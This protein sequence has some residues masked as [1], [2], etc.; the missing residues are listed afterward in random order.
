MSARKS[1]EI[2]STPL[3]PSLEAKLHIP[4]AE[5]SKPSFPWLVRSAAFARSTSQR[6]DT[7]FPPTDNVS[8]LTR[9]HDN[10][11]LVGLS[12][13]Q[14]TAGVCPGR[15]YQTTPLTSSAPTISDIYCLHRAETCTPSF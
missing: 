2:M 9:D 12:L 3:S 4:D 8:S 7:I 13:V 1:P 11:S 15:S 10:I 5:D 14:H 6:M